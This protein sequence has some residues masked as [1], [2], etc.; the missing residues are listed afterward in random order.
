MKILPVNQGKHMV[1]YMAWYLI[2]LAL[3]K[4]REWGDPFLLQAN[5]WLTRSM[6]KRQA[7]AARFSLRW[8]WTGQWF[9]HPFGLVLWWVG[10]LSAQ[11]H[12]CKKSCQW[13]KVG[14]SCGHLDILIA[15]ICCCLAHQ[16]VFV[17]QST[18]VQFKMTPASRRAWES[19]VARSQELNKNLKFNVQY[20][21]PITNEAWAPH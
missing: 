19:F 9:S 15:V 20:W 8:V 17:I 21:L 7:L 16:I 10:Y 18:I 14:L 11:Q 5:W 4:F 13:R 6:Q 1:V 3:I 12:C 2:G